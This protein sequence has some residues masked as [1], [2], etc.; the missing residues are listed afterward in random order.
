MH[1]RIRLAVERER[2]LKR[3]LFE[4]AVRVGRKRLAGEALSF[5]ERLID[6]VLDRLVRDKVRARFGGRLKAMIS[7]GAPLNPEIGGV[8]SA[9][10][11]PPPPGPAPARSAPARLRPPPGALRDQPGAPPPRPAA[12]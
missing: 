7:G 4:R 6:P 3:R 1:Q 5:G 11:G 8:F 9:P 12:A 10:P 2:G